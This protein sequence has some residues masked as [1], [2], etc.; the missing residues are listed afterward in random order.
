MPITP[1]GGWH[2]ESTEGG[3]SKPPRRAIQAP[4]GAEAQATPEDE[5]WQSQ[6][7]RLVNE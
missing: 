4:A 7:K 2:Q 5:G 3:L 1:K 6:V